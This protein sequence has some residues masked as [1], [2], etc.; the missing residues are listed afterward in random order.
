MAGAPAR[1]AR[2]AAS[3][4]PDVPWQGARAR[5]VDA[6]GG[7]CLPDGAGG[8]TGS[9]WGAAPRGGVF[10]PPARGVPGSARARRRAE[11]EGRRAVRAARGRLVGASARGA[12]ASG[13]V[14]S[15]R[16][17]DVAA[18]MV[19][20]VPESMSREPSKG[21]IRLVFPASQGPRVLLDGT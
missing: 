8:T 11:A 2:V 9:R 5:G 21:R 1:R 4:C 12:R 15:K 6:A 10:L 7:M 18:V 16:Q 13:V 14:E 20:I 19:A 17:A 3:R